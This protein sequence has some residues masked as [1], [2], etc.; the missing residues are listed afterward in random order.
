MFP[1][2]FWG[3]G[4]FKKNKMPPLAGIPFFEMHSFFFLLFSL[5]PN[6]YHGQKN[7]KQKI[8]STFLCFTLHVKIGVEQLSKLFPGIIWVSLFKPL[9]IPL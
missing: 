3:C 4:H 8:W 5:I 6:K 7:K 9:K 1:P 2:L